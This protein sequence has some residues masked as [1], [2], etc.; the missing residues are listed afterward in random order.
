MEISSKLLRSEDVH[1]ATTLFDF[2]TD[3][4]KMF[5]DAICIHIN[6]HAR[7]LAH[8]VLDTTDPFAS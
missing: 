2:I 5:F 4:V 7:A 3:A 8:T 1:E 6:T